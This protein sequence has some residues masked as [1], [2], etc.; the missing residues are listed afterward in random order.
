MAAPSPSLSL[1]DIMHPFSPPPTHASKA[2][3]PPPCPRTSTPEPLE[4]VEIEDMRRRVLDMGWGDLS[5][6]N[7]KA[8]S[9]EKELADMLLRITHPAALPQPSQLHAQ[10]ETISNLIQQ[11]D[12]LVTRSMEEHERW[13]SEKEGWA[14]AAH[15]LIIQG[16]REFSQAEKDD[17]V[18]A[19]YAHVTTDASTQRLQEFERA[20]STLQ[21]DKKMLQQKLSDTLS[22]LASLESELAQLKPLLL[23]QPFALTH[24][25]PTGTARGW[26]A[27][28]PSPSTPPSMRRGRGGR[29][30]YDDVDGEDEL[31]SDDELPPLQPRPQFRNPIL[32]PVSHEQPSL[33]PPFP[34]SP[35]K[36][37]GDYYRRRESPASTVHYPSAQYSKPGRR[38]AAGV[39]GASGK[40]TMSDARTEHLLLAARKIGMQRATILSGAFAH[41]HQAPEPA[42]NYRQRPPASPSKAHTSH[43]PRTPRRAANANTPLLTRTPLGQLGSSPQPR[44]PLQSLLSAAQSVLSTPGTA[45]SSMV[46]SPLAKR[47]KLNHPATSLGADKPFDARMEKGKGKETEV[48]KEKGMERERDME[49]EITLTG[50]VARV[51]SALDFLADQAEVYSTQP[52]SQ[53]SAGDGDSQPR[54]VDE[55][56]SPDVEME[57]ASNPADVAGSE[58]APRSNRNHVKG[59][60][61]A[62][63]RAS[64]SR[65]GT[66]GNE[67]LDVEEGK[68]QQ[69][70][71]EH[72]SQGTTP[73]ASLG[74]FS[75]PSATFAEGDPT[76]RRLPRADDRS[77]TQTSSPSEPLR[78]PLTLAPAISLT[79][80]ASRSPAP[81]AA[82]ADAPSDPRSG[83]GSPSMERHG[84]RG[85]SA[86][87]VGTE[88]GPF[89]TFVLQHSQ[90]TAPSGADPAALQ[91]SSSCESMAQ[92]PGTSTGVATRVVESVKFA[93]D[94]PRRTRSPYIKWTKEE[95]E[96]LAKAVAKYGQKWD[97]VQKALPSRGYH[98]VRQRW[99]RK[100]GVFD[101]SK[102]DLSS[103]ETNAAAKFLNLSTAP[104]TDDDGR[105]LS[106]PHEAPNPKLGLAPLNSEKNIT[107]SNSSGGTSTPLAPS[108]STAGRSST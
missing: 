61:K 45:P 51:K 53:D 63:D 99:L 89:S 6:G 49:T 69:T 67:L 94:A 70:I 68:T 19:Q 16:R 66:P 48:E 29:Q 58:G 27:S 15:A 85:L 73:P 8:G 26:S 105:S 90:P 71:I 11:R 88:P 47:R 97:L 4:P 87:A 35:Q 20:N 28:V 36:P 21:S 59:K 98:Q 57:D 60:E 7:E 93:S 14:R 91:P 3:S 79:P 104:P 52:A 5:R 34:L 76:P 102:L 75:D 38:K 92:E 25:H 78:A 9:S 82:V 13:E 37:R 101:G 108:G 1:S 83:T 23:L 50:G 106:E 40:P 54:D 30:P 55:A 10:A 95:D 86:P 44:T 80:R 12:F 62:S 46:E 22:R 107:A 39:Q 77:V 43:S 65:A 17:S 56:T 84:S 24:S 41:L 18:A 72:K 42:P 31:E 32:R 81:L 64:T 96:L 100:L 103:L 2:A 33:Q 74:T